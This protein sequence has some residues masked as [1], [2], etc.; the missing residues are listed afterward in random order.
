MNT[1][2][3]RKATIDDLAI[4]QGLNEELC[5]KEHNEFDPNINPKYSFSN[6]GK[7][8]FTFR[9]T[10]DDSLVLVAESGTDIVGY[11]A[12]GFIQ[13][14]D[15][16]LSESMAEAENMFVKESHRG[17]GIGGRLLNEFE[18]WCKERKVQRIR[19][20]ASAA[21][22]GAIKLYK[23][24]GAKEVSVTLEKDLDEVSKK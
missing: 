1:I 6:A 7:E 20:V 23:S 24:L 18:K 4:I 11:I 14:E 5:I 19:F 3:I 21:N 8:Y 10:R 17:Q 2:T 12:G 9:I 22:S 13:K 15:Y 16:L